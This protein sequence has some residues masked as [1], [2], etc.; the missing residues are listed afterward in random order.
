MQNRGLM[1]SVIENAVQTGRR[2]ADPIAGRFRFYDEVNDIT[3]IMDEA[4]NK[5][6]TVMPG[7]R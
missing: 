6:I 7:S 5:V 1:P 3:V 4:K 2:S